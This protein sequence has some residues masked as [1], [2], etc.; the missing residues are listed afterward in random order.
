MRHR[1]IKRP[2][3]DAALLLVCTAGIAAAGEID[4]SSS[5]APVRGI[6]KSV[7]QATL[8]TDLQAR[9][10]RLPLR[11]GQ[12]F[13]KGDLLVEFECGKV[14]AEL[15]AALAEHRGNLATRDN[16]RSLKK[17]NAAG[18]YDVAIAESA[19]EKSEASVQAFQIRVTQCTIVA[20]FAGR[21]VDLIVNEFDMPAANGALMRIVDDSNL[22][23]ELIAPSV[24]LRWLKPGTAFSLLVDETGTTLPARVAQ[25]GAAV[26]AVSQ[27][28]KITGLIA[29]SAEGVLPGMSGTASFNKAGQ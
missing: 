4:P 25:I 6:I 14:R 18:S 20:P 13:Q 5:D 9:I 7:H 3:V 23:I 8:A 1:R 27:T 24:W 21:I 22:E 29:G 15:D 17:L 11:E 12:R 2:L 19:A 16:S 28:V 26:D 10:I